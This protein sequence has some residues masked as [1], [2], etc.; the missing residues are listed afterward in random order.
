MQA[1]GFSLLIKDL[2]KEF[3]PVG[4]TVETTIKISN[5]EGNHAWFRRLLH[6]FQKAVYGHNLEIVAQVMLYLC[7]LLFSLH[8][9]C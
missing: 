2:L 4:N 5:F 7:A 6:E 1:H 8:A 9:A 3:L